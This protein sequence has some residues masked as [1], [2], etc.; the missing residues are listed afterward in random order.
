MPARI[1]ESEY[2]RLFGADPP[3]PKGR[4]PKRMAA[5]VVPL[6]A[7]YGLPTPVAEYRFHETRKWR[8][9]L[10]WPDLMLALEIEGGVWTRGRHVR[11][12]GFLEDVSK[13][14]AA[15]SAGWLV[16]RCTWADIDSGKAFETVREAMG[17]PK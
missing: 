6:F 4:K 13:Y 1:S 16:L 10:A 15:T 8:F 7:H 12:K 9:D 11:P 17:R 5:D 14:N 2:R 3:K